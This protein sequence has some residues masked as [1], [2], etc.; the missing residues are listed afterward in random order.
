MTNWYNKTVQK[1]SRLRKTF[2]K[3]FASG[4][5]I[6]VFSAWGLAAWKPG[7]ILGMAYPRVARAARIEGPVQAKCSIRADGS[8]A[9]VIIISGH[10]QL[11][12]SVK[13]NL[14]HWTFQNVDS[15]GGIALD[16]F[17]VTYTFQLRGNCDKYNKCD[18]EFWYEYPDRVSVISEMPNLNPGKSAS[19]RH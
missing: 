4:A 9:N 17:V 2:H 7:R 10:P 1:Q 16:E 8:V 11:Q 15:D 18:E 13:D 5:L 6:V 19:I 14:L 12:Q 3:I